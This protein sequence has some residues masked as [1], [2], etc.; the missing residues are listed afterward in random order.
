MTASH[1]APLD[2]ADPEEPVGATLLRM[3][4]ALRLTGKELADRVGMSQPKISRIERGQGLPDP[5]DI[6]RI[7]RELGADDDLVRVLM[8]RAERAHDRLT[9]WRPTSASLAGRQRS[10]AQWESTAQVL[11]TFETAVVPGL[12][13]TSGYVRSILVAFQSLVALDRTAPPDLA[14]AADD[15]AL[16]AAVSGRVRRQEVLADQSKTFRFVLTE[17]VLRSRF[18][19]P[20]EMLAQIA[21]LREVAA[22]PEHIVLRIVPDDAVVDIPP[23]HGFTLYDDRM[24]IV[25]VFNTGLVSRGR[26]DARQYRQ[27]FDWFE[28]RAES[29]VDPILARYERRY[30]EELRRIT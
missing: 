25:D 2:P 14:A 9:D 23:M 30:L 11:R 4:K 7:A 28:S 18:C 10:M 22:G 29:D 16:L 24:V 17:T 13:Q 20:I 6:G 19:P 1:G 5:D 27:V 21:R 8:E 3:R 12:L 26:N 15:A